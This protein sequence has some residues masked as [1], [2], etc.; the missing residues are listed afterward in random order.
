MAGTVSLSGVCVG[1]EALCSVLPGLAP[2][3]LLDPRVP[4][5]WALRE[6]AVDDSGVR[7]GGQR[8]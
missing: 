2:Q 6:H 4:R 7:T 3:Q 1:N 5:L 8:G